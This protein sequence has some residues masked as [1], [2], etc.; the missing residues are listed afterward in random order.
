MI[1]WVHRHN[2]ELR[3][4]NCDLHFSVR[5]YLPFYLINYLVINYSSP[6]S[7]W[8]KYPF[9]KWEEACGRNWVT[10]GSILSSFYWAVRGTHR[11]RLSVSIV[12]NLFLLNDM[13]SGHFCISGSHDSSGSAGQSQ[14]NSQQDKTNLG[15]CY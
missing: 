7:V 15:Y 1:P 9:K 2:L 3:E 4:N 11:D 6:A 5:P 8:E 12:F 13:F 10:L 14:D